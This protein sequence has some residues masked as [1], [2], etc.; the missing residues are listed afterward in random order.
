M[1]LMVCCH[2][3]HGGNP[4]SGYGYLFIPWF[5]WIDDLTRTRMGV[6]SSSC[7]YPKNAGWL[8]SSW[9][10][11]KSKMDDLKKGTLMT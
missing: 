10:I 4:H 6:Y 9:K 3:S 5:S 11:S 8:F 2:P 1:I 7:G